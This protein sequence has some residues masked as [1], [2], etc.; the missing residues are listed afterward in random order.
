MKKGSKIGKEKYKAEWVKKNPDAEVHFVQADTA[1][2][3]FALIKKTYAD[4]G[5]ERGNTQKT[6]PHPE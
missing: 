6:E 5:E 1:K 2:E 4:M 3:F